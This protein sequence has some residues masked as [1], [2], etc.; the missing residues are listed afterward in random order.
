[1]T[2]IDKPINPIENIE[3]AR[4]PIVAVEISAVESLEVGGCV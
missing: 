1:M 2:D 3:M 4:Y